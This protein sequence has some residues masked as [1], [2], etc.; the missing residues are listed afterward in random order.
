MLCR[1]EHYWPPEKSGMRLVADGLMVSDGTIHDSIRNIVLSAVEGDG[2][3][4]RI[5]SP[6]AESQI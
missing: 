6:I 2:M 3:E 5:V 4:M 1:D